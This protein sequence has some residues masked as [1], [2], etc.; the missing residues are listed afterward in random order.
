MDEKKG[1]TA[2]Q[3]EDFS[4]WYTQ[5]LLKTELA[6]YSQVSGCMILRP[7]GYAIWELIRGFL[8]AELGKRGVENCYFPLLIPEKLLAK[9][10][11]HVEGFT[12]E[13]AWVT[14]SGDSALPERLAVRPT[15]ETVMYEAYSRWIRSYQQL[16]M[17]LNQW[18]NVIRWEFK[19]PV[20]FLR[21]REFLWQEG[22]T[23]HPTRE[24]AD[25][26]VMDILHLYK[27]LFEELLAVPVFEGRKS[28]KEKFAGALYTTSVETFLPNNRAIQCGTS[29]A[30]GQ[31]F[32]KAF[33]IQFLDK[34]EKKKYAWQN[35][36]G[37]S[38][39]SIG[40]MLMM[41]GDDKGLIIPPRVAPVQ[42]VVVPILFDDSKTEV[43]KASKGVA[44]ALKKFRVRLDDREQYTSGWKFNEWEMKGVP[45]RIEVGPKDVK[46][47][48]VV[49]VRRDTGEKTPVG[50]KD[51]AKA[52]EALLDDVHSSLFQRA[53][54]RIDDCVVET[55]D[56][57]EFLKALEDRKLVLAPWCGDPECEDFLRAETKGVK[58][59]NIPFGQEGVGNC[60]RCDRPAVGRAYFAKSY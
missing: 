3:D 52:V 37:V 21:T 59:L 42:V 13:V 34:D 40:I 32:S 28:D 23:V 24:S 41:H 4:A 43:L 6:D 44:K 26:E 58:S 54:K 27:R 7:Y 8:D 47:N 14:H 38:T 56:Y 12:P 53:K 36:W 35:S 11:E 49:L 50:V 55:E 30:L 48:Q 22:H 60:V 1:V 19:H 25:D 45:L 16:P 31:N 33:D 18:V 57:D 9:E 39:R 51:L 46:N 2:K 10:K 20:P 5:T 17:R 15:S 29:H